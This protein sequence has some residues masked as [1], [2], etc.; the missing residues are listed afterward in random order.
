MVLKHIIL[1]ENPVNLNA[2]NM[3]Y[4][5]EQ[6]INRCR[7]QDARAQTYLYKKYSPGIFRVA[8]RYSKCV[9]DAEDATIQTLNIVLSKILSYRGDCTNEKLF[10]GW[11]RRI[12][13]N[14]ALTSIRKNKLQFL[15]IDIYA[16]NHEL[17]YDM[18]LTNAS[19]INNAQANESTESYINSK[20][21]RLEITKLPNKQQKIFNMFTDGY[22][23]NEI[24]NI[25]NTTEST[26]KTQYMRAKNKLQKQLS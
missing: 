11:M 24:A 20:Y 16:A 13:I 7:A 12:A 21:I 1:A 6:L 4:N 8:R 10:F 3:S 23:H 18:L 15:D 14:V 17:D 22:R 9:E 5:I 26:S 19:C 2:N 25:M